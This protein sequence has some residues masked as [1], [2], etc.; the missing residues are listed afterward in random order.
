MT[1]PISNQ[2]DPDIVRW[3]MASMADYFANTVNSSIS[4]VPPFSVTGYT[5]NSHETADHIEMRIIGPHLDDASGG[6][7]Q[8]YEVGLSFLMTFRQDG[9]KDVFTLD[10]WL[11]VYG[12]ALRKPINIYKRGDGIDDD[13][14]LLGCFQLRKQARDLIRVDRY[15]FMDANVPVQQASIVSSHWMWKQWT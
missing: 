11:G 15:G 1:A 6:G 5:L 2:S 12:D 13:E 10:R 4:P 7:W 8:Q 3:V 9:I 14:S